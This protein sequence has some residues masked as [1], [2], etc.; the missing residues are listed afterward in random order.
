MTT[1]ANIRTLAPG[2]EQNPEYVYIG[3]AGRGFDGRFGNPFPLGPHEER[4]S[5][6]ERY[7]AY[8]WSRINADSPEYAPDFTRAVAGLHGRTLVCFCAPKPCHGDILA[9]AAAWLN[10]IDR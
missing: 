3:R 9:A 5:T 6:L 10:E 2:W 8:L 7:R 4:G 1:V